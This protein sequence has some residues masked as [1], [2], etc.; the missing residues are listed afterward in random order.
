MS[1][2]SI[3]IEKPK[4]IY[5]GDPMCS[6]CYGIAEELA[7][8]KDM[9]GETV[10]YELVV[11]G[12]RAGGGDQWNTQFR[13]F[14][15]HHWEEVSAASDQPFSYDLLDQDQFEYD[16]EPSCR[17]VV[18]VQEMKPSVQFIFFKS[19]QKKFYQDN[20]DPNHINFYE[21]ICEDHGIDFK[22]F[23]KKFKSESARL[24]TK[25]HFDR[26]RALGV[27]S[28]PTIILQDGDQYHIIAKGFAKSTDMVSRIKKI[29]REAK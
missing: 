27:N 19:I 15:R 12:L 25:K 9:L 24:K 1:I 14:L 6:W 26:A 21:S 28:F 29:L 5:V 3:Q 8:T 7:T 2:S 13:E 17:A 23:K 10:D 22:A 20:E 18:V 16:T 4:L 11:G